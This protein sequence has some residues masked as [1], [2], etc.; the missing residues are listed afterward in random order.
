[1]VNQRTFN[2]SLWVQFPVPLFLTT[3]QRYDRK[4]DEW[5]VRKGAG[6]TLSPFI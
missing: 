5:N 2:P 4:H 1:M 3:K 6:W